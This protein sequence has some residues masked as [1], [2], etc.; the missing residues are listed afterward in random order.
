VEADTLDGY[1]TDDVLKAMSAKIAG[2]PLPSGYSINF[3]GENEDQTENFNFLMKSFFIASGLILIILVIQFN[4]VL[5]ALIIF[6]SV[7]LSFIGVFAGLLTLDMRFSVIMT[8]LGIISL[9]GTVVNNA[10]ILIDFAQQF[11]A[12]GHSAYEAAIESGKIR[13][14]PV[15]L[16]A[17][18]T[19]LGLI[20]MAIGWSL[21][22]HS[23]PPKI[24]AGA[25]SSQWWAP[26]AIVVIFG[27]SVST[28]LTLF[29][30]PTLFCFFD[31]LREKTSKYLS[32]GVHIQ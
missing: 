27:L 16:T 6:S 5:L 12:K 29:L 2:I 14:R 23:F 19:V 18:T 7:I 25:E 11:K 22:V 24:I 26:M 20:P 28:F 13:I 8:G 15:L 9:A 30:S 4:S 21:E 17:I 10:I 3:T 31:G 32:A 1:G